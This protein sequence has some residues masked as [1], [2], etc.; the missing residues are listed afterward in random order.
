[1]AAVSTDQLVAETKAEAEAG[2]GAEEEQ[3]GRAVN[4]DAHIARHANRICSSRCRLLDCIALWATR[5]LGRTLHD[6]AASRPDHNGYR[7]CRRSL[8][9]SSLASSQ[10][11]SS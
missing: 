5:E 8:G 6:P 7:V 11:S 3:A 2:V 1:M 9:N 10:S 4:P